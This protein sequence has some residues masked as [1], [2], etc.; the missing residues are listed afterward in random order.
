M[1]CV[2]RVLLV[3]L[4]ALPALG[5]EIC[6]FRAE[7]HE[8]PFSRWLASQEVTCADAATPIQFPSGLWNVFVRGANAVSAAPLLVD[9]DAAPG[10]IAPELAAG[11][12]VLPLL[13]EGQTGVVYATRRASAFPV[14]GERVTVPADEELWLFVLEKATP[15][16]VIPIA[17]LPPGTERRVDARNGGPSAVI[18]WLQVPEAERAAL[19]KADIASPAVRAGSRNGDPLPRPAALHGAFFR[20]K[21]VAPGNADLRVEGRGWVPG[22]RVVK[23][24]PGVTVAAAP[25]TL[26]AA[27]TLMVHWNTQEDLH[28]LDRSL[29]SCNADDAPP[30]LEIVVSKCATPGPSGERDCTPI[31]TEKAEQFFGSMTFED[32]VPGSY[33][34]EMRF[35]K[36]PPA[37]GFANVR[38][39]GIGDLRVFASYFSIQGS[40]TRGGNPLGEDVRLGF[41]EGYGFASAESEDY[42]AVLRMPFMTSDVPITVAACDGSPRAVYLSDQPIR[43]RTR[44]NIDLPG[45]QLT[46]HVND[47]FTREPLPGASVKLEAMS[48]SKPPRVVFTTTA[49][50]DERGNVVLTD[51][52]IREIHLT[53]SLAGYEKRRVEPFSMLVREEQT[54]DVQMIPLR[55]MRGRIHSERPF[56]GGVVIWFSPTGSETERAD[57]A[58]DGTFAFQNWHTPDETMSVVSQSHPLWVLRAPKTERRETINLRFPE[59]PVAAFDV[60][61]AAA[62]PPGQTR[63]IG[64]AIGGVRVPQPVLAQHQTLR[65]DPP[66]M[67]GAG[68]QHFR[69]LLATGPIEVILG[70]TVEELDSRARGVDFFA[71]PQFADAPRERVTAADVVFTVK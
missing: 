41:P 34:A 52:P 71:F 9:G 17:A 36:L 37:A 27:G 69:D 5:N 18:G 57:L 16:A 51:V 10:Q 29:G 4:L 44:F 48:I 42:S 40:V 1:H 31:R 13:A 67:R 11:A 64:L 19:A 58:P 35:G 20:V 65:R 3:L 43:P 38:P 60:W 54:V 7:G 61:L 15:V 62:V 46:I 22:R 56:D 55:G 68:P 24:Q 30:Q 8:N 49:T 63:Y 66:L 6:R 14:A 28:A 26:R 39:L 70:P 33:R 47:T 21:D 53:V 50:S 59:A 32:V 12:T 45:N 23:V 25:L 2:T